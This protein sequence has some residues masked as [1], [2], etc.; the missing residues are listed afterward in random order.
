MTRKIKNIISWS[1]TG[2][3][4]LVF[5]SSASMKFLGGEEVLKGMS[6]VGI[7]TGMLKLIGTIELVSIL[8][9]IIPR[10]GLL[11][12]LLLAAYLGGAIAT[13]IEHQ[14]P[15]IAAVIVECLVWITAAMRFPELS[16]RF[17]GNVEKG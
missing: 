7:S 16:A 17:V 2:L 6:A 3:L 14:Q 10:T 1:L 11:G 9:F 5:L 12:T 13:H 4:A 8:L 15:F